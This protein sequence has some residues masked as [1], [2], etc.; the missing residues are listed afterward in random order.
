[1]MYDKFND[2]SQDFETSI[3]AYVLMPEHFHLLVHS[4]TGLRI[5]GFLQSARQSISGEAKHIIEIG[6]D[7]FRDYCR[8][9]NIDSKAFYELTAGKSQFRFWKEKPRVIA[10]VDKADI[11]N[12]VDYIHN[13]PV[14]R[15]WLNILPNG[16]IR[17]IKVL[18]KEKL[19]PQDVALVSLHP[20][21]HELIA[22]TQ[23]S[24]NLKSPY[25]SPTPP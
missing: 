14:R 7:S 23:Y 15:G 17:V 13:N 20:E 18:L 12:K 8:N 1:M 16:L 10:L 19:W 6:N 11:G 4:K 5:Q 25:T 22:L 9:N 24:L 21:A 2:K 3:I